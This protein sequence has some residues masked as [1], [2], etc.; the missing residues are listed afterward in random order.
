MRKPIS[1]V[2]RG[3]Q[4]KP[5]GLPTSYHF[6]AALCLLGIAAGC[7]AETGSGGRKVPGDGAQP[8]PGT[9]QTMGNPPP[10]GTGSL[11]TTPGTGM[12]LMPPPQPV[13]AIVGPTMLRRLTN[14]E[15]RNTVKDLLQLP[16]IPSDP[17]QSDALTKGFD[18]VSG[19]LTVPPGLASQYA[20]IAA[21]QAQAFAVPACAAP[22]T[23]AECAAT[24]VTSFGKRAF[25]RPITPAEEQTY[26]GMYADQRTRA[27]HAGGIRHLVQTMLQSPH[28]LYRFELGLPDAGPARS[29]TSYE[30]ATELAYLV[31]ATTPDDALLAAADNNALLT[32]AQIAGEARRLLSLEAAKP[33]LRRFV[34]SF[35]D[36]LGLNQIAKDA[37]VYPIFTPAVRSAVQDETAA[38]VDEIL[39]KGDG[40]YASFLSAPFS[41]VNAELAPLY[42]VADPGQGATLV[43]TTLNPLERQGL[44]THASVLAS[45]SKPGESS[46]IHR[47][48]FIRV[49]LLCQSLP[50]PPANVPML[51]PPQPNLTTRERVAA[52]SAD[53]ACSG[54]HSLIDPLGF[55]LENYDGIGKFRLNEGG[56]AVDT[57]GQFTSTLDLDGPFTGGI[58]LATKLAASQEAKQ[59]VTQR[60]YGWAFGRSALDT[61]RPVVN[62]IATPLGLTGLDIRE[63]VVAIAQSDN[64]RFRSFR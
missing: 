41:F 58:E 59:C 52:H 12:S 19:S 7:T 11:P 28:L 8:A 21:L 13:G 9:T 16:A 64:F 63:V 17:L 54:C 37:A 42:G 53:A 3:I 43:K 36:T 51:A 18:N 55:G 50:A 49:G 29:L 39:W 20:D 60:A 23:E 4:T 2:S 22:M 26:A 40:T 56:K 47:G 1:R 5:F 31:T 14:I 61:E 62:A 34:L 45:H 33:S 38:F 30:V 48:K 15:Y 32:P 57:A 27:D 25:R 44:L 6:S 46:P 10:G 35:V 24:F